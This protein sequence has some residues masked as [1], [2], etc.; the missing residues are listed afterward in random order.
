MLP[1]GVGNELFC[2]EGSL[3]S[4]GGG[5]MELLLQLIGG[6]VGLCSIVL[7]G[8]VGGELA[9][10]DGLL[11]LHG[12]GGNGLLLQEKGGG[13]GPC[14]APFPGGVGS[15][16]ACIAPWPWGDRCPTVSVRPGGKD[17]ECIAL[18]P[19]N[20]GKL[21][22][23]GGGGGGSTSSSRRSAL[24]SYRLQ[25]VS[26]TAYAV[27]LFSVYPGERATFV[28]YDDDEPTTDGGGIV[29]PD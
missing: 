18:S 26:N 12:G 20:R 16:L 29:R 21:S 24:H 9:C 2:G 17:G 22:V 8:G 27:W 23:G 28:K 7:P 11:S 6:G 4:H 10:G 15:E 19:G 14:S 25:S 3:L 1:G 5:G 13:E